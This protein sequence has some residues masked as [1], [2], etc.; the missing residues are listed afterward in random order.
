MWTWGHGRRGYHGKK[1]TKCTRSDETLFILRHTSPIKKTGTST[2]QYTTA[3]LRFPRNAP[4]THRRAK[5]CL[6]GSKL[7]V[8]PASAN[9][10][11][12]H[13]LDRHTT[14]SPSCGLATNQRARFRPSFGRCPPHAT[15]STRRP[16]PLLPGQRQLSVFCPTFLIC[17]WRL[18]TLHGG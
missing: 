12:K 10:T 3:P 11:Y 13:Q 17:P 4:R 5:S 8:Q 15:P 7:H 9:I 16:E 2:Y 14:W 6:F 1:M 18:V